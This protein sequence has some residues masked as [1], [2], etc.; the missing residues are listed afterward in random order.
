MIE[1]YRG[2]CY[3]LIKKHIP[4]GSID[5]L[6]ADPPYN[7]EMKGGGTLNMKYKYRKEKINWFIDEEKFLEIVKPKLKNFHAYIWCGKDQVDI[8]TTFAK[9]NK[10]HFDIL[11]WNKF[12]CIPNAFNKYLSDLEYCIFIRKPRCCT[13]N[14]KLAGNTRDFYSKL[15][16]DNVTKNDYSHPTQKPLWMV[17][18]HILISTKK[19]DTVL[20]PF[21]GTGTTG[22]ACEALQRN[23]IGMEIDKKYFDISKNRIENVKNENHLFT[24]EKTTQYSMLG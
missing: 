9:R 6:Y 23:F 22:A 13:F 20:D 21:M 24:K 5:L 17:K 14:N 8:Y 16:L 15:M 3:K 7:I 19:N 18:R 10:Y 12:N 4:D 1:L 11:V 2:D